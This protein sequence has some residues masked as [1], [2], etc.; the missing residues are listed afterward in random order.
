[1]LKL[2]CLKIQNSYLQK[3][4]HKK[5]FAWKGLNKKKYEKTANKKVY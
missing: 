5:V 4:F 2:I 3:T 1:M